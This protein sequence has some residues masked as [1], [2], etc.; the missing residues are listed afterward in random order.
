MLQIEGI[1][2]RS[3]AIDRPK[4]SLMYDSQATQ[5]RAQ[6][7]SIE[8]V[9]TDLDLVNDSDYILSIVP[10]RDAIATAQRIVDASNKAQNNSRT[11]PLFFFDLHAV[12]PKSAR[13]IDD[14]ISKS[15]P[16]IK[17]I[18]GGIIGGPPSQKDDKT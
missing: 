5:T 13:T 14:L 11:D 17:F 15:S 6:K 9:P 1:D 12:S 10:P 18:D 2:S 4:I 3:Y 8:L 7:N 16:S